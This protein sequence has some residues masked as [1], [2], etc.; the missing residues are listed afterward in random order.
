M[1]I[2]QGAYHPPPVLLQDEFTSKPVSARVGAVPLELCMPTEKVVGGKIFPIIHS[3]GSLLC[4]P[5][6]ATPHP[7]AVFDQNQF[8]T[9]KLT[10]GST[11]W[12][13]PPST[14]HINF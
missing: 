5:V 12:L 11:Q 4:F 10:I 14:W 1:T 7:A 8:G 3:T 13:C 2:S 6:T 9:A